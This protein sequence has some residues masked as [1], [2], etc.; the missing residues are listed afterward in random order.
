MNVGWVVPCSDMY[1]ALTRFHSHI[2]KCNWSIHIFHDH[3][4]M[5]NVET[6][7]QPEL[8][9]FPRLRRHYAIIHY[10]LD[11][12]ETCRRQPILHLTGQKIFVSFSVEKVQFQGLLLAYMEG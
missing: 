9:D 7:Y 10:F 6:V 5:K 11:G 8:S 1:R 2:S 3:R 4:L 12:C